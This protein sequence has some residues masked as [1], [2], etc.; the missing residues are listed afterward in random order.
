[1]LYKWTMIIIWKNAIGD[2]N[3]GEHCWILVVRMLRVIRMRMRMMRMLRV[4]PLQQRNGCSGYRPLRLAQTNIK[5][6]FNSCVIWNLKFCCATVQRG[7]LSLCEIWKV[8]H[9]C[10]PQNLSRPAPNTIFVL[11][12][13]FLLLETN[14]SAL[15]TFNL[16]PMIQSSSRSNPKQK[17]IFL[18]ILFFILIFTV[19]KDAI[20]SKKTAGTVTTIDGLLTFHSY[21]IK[22][23]FEL[24]FKNLAA[25]LD[26]HYVNK[27]QNHMIG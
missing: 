7:F 11:Q 2:E 9:N 6:N 15:R 12:N 21:Y 8:V 13:I 20:Q 1:M 3:I 4:N 14:Q 17:E 16:C 18:C 23:G 25:N 5:C 27:Q 22:V 26:W 24:Y 10:A 19:G